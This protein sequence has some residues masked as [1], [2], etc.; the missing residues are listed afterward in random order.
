MA[1]SIDRLA[2]EVEGEAVAFGG[3]LQVRYVPLADGMRLEQLG[4]EFFVGGDPAK[5]DGSIDRILE[6]IRDVA[7]SLS[8]YVNREYQEFEVD[9]IPLDVR[10]N[11]THFKTDGHNLSVLKY[12]PRGGYPVEQ[13]IDRARLGEDVNAQLEALRTTADR[14]AW[15]DLRRLAGDKPVARPGEPIG[16]FISYRATRSASAEKL[17][18][19][20]VEEGLSPWYDRWEIA[21]GDSIPGKIEEG[22]ERSV[23]FI[24]MFT[25]DYTQGRW[26]TEGTELSYC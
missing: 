18:N 25:A 4:G 23:A 10:W 1:T 16:V 19:R 24:P 2:V 11:V 7:R 9:G 3:C 8:D 20:L 6:R 21:A 13:S 15:V 22:F 17:A 12:G 14:L 26:C 5:T